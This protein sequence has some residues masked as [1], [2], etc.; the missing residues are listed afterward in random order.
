MKHTNK[1]NR[2]LNLP[3]NKFE[4]FKSTIIRL[5]LQVCER[6]HTNL[7]CPVRVAV[8]RPH[9]ARPQTVVPQLPTSSPPDGCVSCG[10]AVLAATP[11]TTTQWLVKQD[12]EL[13]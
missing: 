9:E 2:S 10:T 4:L 12:V 6:K 13:L 7:E 5:L 8:C 1:Q 3:Q 11:P